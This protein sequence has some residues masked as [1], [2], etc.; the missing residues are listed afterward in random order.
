M[1]SREGIMPRSLVQI[2]AVQKRII[3]FYER[4]E[5]VF[6]YSYNKELMVNKK[7]GLVNKNSQ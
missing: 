6:S 5:S 7:P 4:H 2:Q 3:S 1:Q